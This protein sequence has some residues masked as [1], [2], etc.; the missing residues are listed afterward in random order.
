MSIIGYR[1]LA[2]C[3]LG[4]GATAVVLLTGVLAL[5]LYLKIRPALDS[6][7][8]TTKTVEKFSSYVETEVAAPL[9]QLT[10]FIQGVNQAVGLVSRFTKRGGKHE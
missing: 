3:V 5:L 9:A 6:V 4:F 7:K 8:A 2:I 1:D 10:V